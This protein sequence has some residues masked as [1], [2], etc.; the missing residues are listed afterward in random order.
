MCEM[1]IV[2]GLSHCVVHMANASLIVEEEK[3]A[4]LKIQIT[5]A[6][7]LPIAEVLQ[8]QLWYFDMIS[9]RV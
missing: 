4:H 1:N 3:S 9:W 8:R 6:W 2:W 5:A 7:V